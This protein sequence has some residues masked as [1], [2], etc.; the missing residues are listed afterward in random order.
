MVQIVRVFRPILGSVSPKQAL[1]SPLTIG[2]KQRAVLLG[3]PVHAHREQVEHVHL[4][5]RGTGQTGT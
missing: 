1:F 4:Y 5:N 3:G 2:D